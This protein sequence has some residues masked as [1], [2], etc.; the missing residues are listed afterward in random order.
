MRKLI[1]AINITADGCCDH[2]KGISDD[3]IHRYFA[4]LL[5]Q[6]GVLVYGRKTF[7]LMVP[8]WPDMVKNDSAPTEALRDFARAFDDV[9]RIVVFSRSLPQPEDPKI[10]VVGTDLREEILRLKQE[11]G[12]DMLLGG[13]DVPSQL[14]QMDLVDEYIFVVQP[15]IVGEGRRLLDG[16]SLPEHVRLRL[17]SS[18][19]LSSGSVVLHYTK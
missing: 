17:V 5:R 11:E 7:E 18:Q 1:F 16:V 6:S 3:G 9:E 2:T 19:V 13:V 8:F 10:K 12:K 14:M 4:D 15:L